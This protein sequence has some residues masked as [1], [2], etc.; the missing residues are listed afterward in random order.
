MS[1]RKSSPMARWLVKGLHVSATE[2]D[3]RDRVLSALTPEART[4]PDKATER[5]DLIRD[6]LEAHAEN[7]RL[8]Q[9]VMGGI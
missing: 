9:S 2:C 4:D 8:Y 3:V 5:A 1:K 6:A 7:R